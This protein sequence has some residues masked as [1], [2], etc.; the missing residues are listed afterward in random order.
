MIEKFWSAGKMQQQPS[1]RNASTCE[2]PNPSSRACYTYLHNDS[3]YQN[4]KFRVDFRWR[5][6]LV[7]QCACWTRLKIAMRL[8]LIAAKHSSR[9]SS[10]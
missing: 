2:V 5:L 10:N 4:Q 7:L 3:K 1:S 8:K 6:E 9:L